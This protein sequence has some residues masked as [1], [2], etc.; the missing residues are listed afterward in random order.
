MLGWAANVNVKLQRCE[1]GVLY[2]AQKY[3]LI[4]IIYTLMSSINNFIL[5]NLSI[6]MSMELIVYTLI[7]LLDI[8]MY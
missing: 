3:I 2:S 6:H 4:D 7:I 1:F 8:I 5:L